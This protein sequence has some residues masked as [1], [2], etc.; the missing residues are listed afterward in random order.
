MGIKV[1]LEGVLVSL[2]ADGLFSCQGIRRTA[3]SLNTGP[4]SFGWKQQGD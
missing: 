2:F 4:T 3:S 1:R